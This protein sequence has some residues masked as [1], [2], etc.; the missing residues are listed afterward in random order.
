M[1]SST[2]VAVN[3]SI[4]Y[5]RTFITVIITL[6]TSRVI[7]A[8]L[9]VEDYGIYSLIGGVI[10]MLAFIQNNLARTTQ[11]YLSYYQ[12][13]GDFQYV[14]KIFNNSVCTQLAVAVFLCGILALL[15]NP[16]ILHLVNIPANKIEAA[17]WVYWL[18]LVS[19]FINLQSSP[20][21]AA[22]IA[23]ENMV[24]SSIVQILDAILKVPVA[25]SLIWISETNWNG[26]HSCRFLS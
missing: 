5:V 24:F 22:L 3:T 19:L 4:Q 14:T 1:N 9:G 18:M 15:T 16:V 26:T 13:K 21:L 25:L 2:R 11:R 6:Y 12:G 8:N 10:A 17:T 23:R 20:Y 7:L